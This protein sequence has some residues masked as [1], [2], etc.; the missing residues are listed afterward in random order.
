MTVSDSGGLVLAGDVGGTK[1]N[2]GLFRIGRGRPRPVIA[3]SYADREASSL[4]DLI[5]RFLAEH[6]AQVQAASFGIAGPVRRGLCRATNLPWLVSERGISERF[7]WPRVRLIN[8]L[9]A[10]AKALPVLRRAE[11][12]VVN[13]GK[14]ERGG[15]V[16]IVAPGTGLGMA[17][18]VSHGGT[19]N[20]IPSEGGHVDFAPRTGLQIEL[21]LDL[22]RTMSHVSVE[23]LASG[24]GLVTIHGWLREYRGT[25]TPEWLTELMTSRDPAAAISSA[26]LDGSDELCVEA[27]DLFVSI[28]GAAAG[29]LALMGTTR[30]GMYLGG[31][32]PPKI[33]PRLLNG[34]FME[35]FV[36]KGRFR[37]ILEAIPVRVILNDKAALLGAACF[38]EEAI[39]R[40][41]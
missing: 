14:P 7:G 16:G 24:P 37:G 12:A 31:G 40:I 25:P 13:K 39:L 4:E 36:A 6:R 29:N 1:T 15:I 9:T 19:I 34:P 8:D 28:L 30:G 17:L 32:I 41:E 23:R 20:A 33:L 3:V 22:L 5:A 27:L 2:L 11:F 18:A 38:A 35:A 26:A 21:L 10:T